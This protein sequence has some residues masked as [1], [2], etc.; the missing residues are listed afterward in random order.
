MDITRRGFLKL[1][2]TIG[3]TSAL[4]LNFRPV[5]AY[6]SE[7]NKMNRVKMAKQYHHDLLLLLCGVR[8]HQQRGHGHGQDLQHRG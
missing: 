5:K 1:T 6:A 4:G 3:A 2:G 7:L 8:P